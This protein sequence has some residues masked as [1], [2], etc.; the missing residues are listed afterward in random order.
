MA[1][2]QII[3]AIAVKFEEIKNLYANDEN[4]TDSSIDE[5]GLTASVYF[6]DE[7]INIFWDNINDCASSELVTD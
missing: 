1:N 4:Y 6:K 5:D 2:E 3:N 7:H